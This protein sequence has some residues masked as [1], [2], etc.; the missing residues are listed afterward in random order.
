MT[1]WIPII[2]ATFLVAV[3]A[4]AA[5]Y[6]VAP[7]G[8]DLASGTLEAPWRTLQHAADTAAAG[9]TV[10]VRGGV[11]RES[12]TL[13]RSGRADAPIVFAAYADEGPVIDGE[14]LDVGA[15][16][17]L[18]A[19]SFVS[20]R[21]LEI[22]NVP[23][24]NAVWIQR[25]SDIEL[26]DC[27]VHH[28]FYGI[29]IADGTHDFALTRVEVHHITLYGV[30]VDAAGGAPCFNGTFSECNVHT[31][32]DPTQN[33]DGFALG[34]GDQHSFVF[35]GCRA[36]GVFDGFDISARDTLLTGCFASG[37]GNGGY[38]IWQDDVRLINCVALNNGISN[39]ELD[40]DGQPGTVILEHCT[41]VGVDVFNIWVEN[42]QDRLHMTNCI[43][44]G[45][46]NIGLAFEQRDSSGYVGDYNLFHMAN[47]ERA[48]AVGYEDEFSSRQV[49]EAEWTGLS[50]QDTHSIAVFG[51]LDDLF[52][53]VNAGDLRLADWASAIDAG[54]HGSTPVDFDGLPRPMDGDG[55]DLA[56]P[57]IGAHEY[58][59]EPMDG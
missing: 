40:W 9:D 37:C 15:L 58:P 42:A 48:I 17:R 43:L 5:S 2:L 10:W 36:V 20:L 28:A 46:R 35:D 24:G 54:G 56:I 18:R 22:R 55:D 47:G 4:R 34:H 52:Q 23:G 44:A 12:V 59:G 1:R 45:G 16:V 30:D 11:Y 25:S 31:A 6:V 32:L 38:K 49:A 7:D 21:G 41:L 8:S 53:D 51:S 57:D 3:T 27:D 13:T 14:G 39:V 33:V 50:G 19:V 29:G 26:L